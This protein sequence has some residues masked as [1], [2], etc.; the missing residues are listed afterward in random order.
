MITFKLASQIRTFS[1]TQLSISV[2]PAKRSESWTTP[3]LH[4]PQRHPATGT[5]LRPPPGNYQL[6]NNVQAL[7][8]QANGGIQPAPWSS[9]LCDC[10]SDVPN[11]CGTSGAL[12]ALIAIISGCPFAYSCFYRSK[13]RKQYMLT[14][15]PCI[16]CLV[17][18]FCECCALCQDYRE[19]KHR[20]FDMTL[21]F[22]RLDHGYLHL[23]MDGMEIWKN[24]MEE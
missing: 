2:F 4:H 13:M 18:F 16:D 5:P 1:N 23:D 6:R 12:Y 10:F 17:H 22:L 19:L 20:G 9:G 7:P 3:N 11:S 8:P 21:D 15:S 24:K 14:E